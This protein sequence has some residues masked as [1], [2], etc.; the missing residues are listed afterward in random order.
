MASLRILT[1]FKRF[2]AAWSTST[3]LSGSAI[4]CGST[5]E[6]LQRVPQ[7]DLLLVNCDLPLT[8]RLALRSLNPLV[9]TPPIVAADLVLRRPDS[10]KTRLKTAIHRALLSR[11]AHFIH[12]FRHSPGYRQYFGIGPERSSFVHFKSNLGSNV[13]PSENE[14][15]YVLCFGRSMRDYDTFLAAMASLPYPAAIPRPDFAT[16]QHHKSRFTVPLGQIPP[17]VR[18]LDDDGSTE[19]MVRI[20]D[21]AHLVVLPVLANSLAPS[22]LSVYLNAMSMR[23]CVIISEGP[24]ASDVLTGGQALIVPPEDPALLAQAIRKAW[25]DRDLRT[26]TAACGYDYAVSL[27]GERQLYQRILENIATWHARSHPT[28]P[29]PC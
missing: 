29:R 2:P 10:A 24:G 21:N 8:E 17:N 28:N 20:F 3:G 27:G 12:Y 11:V 26:Q 6:F 23:K 15:E 14:G 22:G 16:L 19:S 7:A 18:L 1:N 4:L 25:E 13:G 5:G 9:S